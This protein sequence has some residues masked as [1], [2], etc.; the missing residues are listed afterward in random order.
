MSQARDSRTYAITGHDAFSEQ[1][2]SS[3]FRPSVTPTH[4]SR[5]DPTYSAHMSS[6]SQSST[7]TPQ[8]LH[9]CTLTTLADAKAAHIQ[10]LTR[11]VKQCLVN[12]EEWDGPV[13]DA[14]MLPY[15]QLLVDAILHYDDDEDKEAYA[16]YTPDEGGGVHCDLQHIECVAWKLVVISPLDLR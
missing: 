14:E 6:N 4:Q 7:I 16:K 8:A 10:R 13:T 3:S 15:V 9:R 5:S 12:G 2:Q 11:E 1:S